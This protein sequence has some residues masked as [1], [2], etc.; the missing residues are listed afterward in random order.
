MIF[1]FAEHLV[2]DVLQE[3]IKSLKELVDIQSQDG[4]WNYSGYMRGLANGMILSLNLLD[5]A[6]EDPYHG[7]QMK[8]PFLDAPERWLKDK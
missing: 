8:Y 6:L 1:K 2:N 5:D 7:K 4:N 3:K